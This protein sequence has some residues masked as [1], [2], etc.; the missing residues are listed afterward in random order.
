M[1]T[2]ITFLSLVAGGIAAPQFASGQQP[3]RKVALYANVGPELTHYDVDVAGTTLIKHSTVT[4]PAGLSVFRVGNDG[5]LTF[6]RKY[7]VDVGDKL[8]FWMG[9]VP[10]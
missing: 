5:K 9:M 4:P 6:A 8:M 2:R 3:S 7:D 1:L 10:L